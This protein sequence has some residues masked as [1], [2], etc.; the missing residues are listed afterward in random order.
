MYK[1]CDSTRPEL[2][3]HSRYH[4]FSDPVSNEVTLIGYCHIGF[5]TFDS[6]VAYLLHSIELIESMTLHVVES[7]LGSPCSTGQ[8]LMC[9]IVV[10]MP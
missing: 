7:W 9:C 4:S 3:P 8:W 1:V 10:E 5:R 2:Y 6:N